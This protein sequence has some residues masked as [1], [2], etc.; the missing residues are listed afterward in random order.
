MLTKRRKIGYASGIVSESVLYNM[1]YT[2][3]LI[4]LTDVVHINPALAGTISMVSIIWDGITDP[5][6]GHMTDKN[7]V[8]KRKVMR[9]SIIPMVVFFVF[10]FT[11]FN[12][13]ASFKV[14]Y[15][16][17]AAVLFWIAY[18]TYTIPYYAICAQITDDYDERTNI[19]GISS[20]INAFA[21]FIGAAAPVVLVE[22]FTGLNLSVETGWMLSAVVVAIIAV[23]FG[24]IAYN[25]TKNLKLIKS[26]EKSEQ[27][28]FKTYLEIIKIKPFKYLLL[29]VVFFMIQ[30]ALGQANL[31]Y[32][33]THRLLV[34]ADAY[35]PI[36]LGAIV[37]GMILFVPLTTKIST[38]K[39]RRYAVILLLSISTLG[40][41]AFFFIGITTVV[42]LVVMLLFYAMGLAVFWTTFYS[43]TY[44]IAELDEMKNNRRRV[45]AI[46][47]LPQFLQ[48]FGAALGMQI[49]GLMLYFFGY[50][51]SKPAQ[52]LAT[53]MGIEYIITV[54]CPI[55]MGL[56]IVFMILYPV[57]KEKYQ[58]LQVAL[59]AKRNGEAYKTDGLEKLL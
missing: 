57:T 46:T 35:M 58:K 44:D 9:A 6:V 53:A 17:L 23:A 29:F 20:F 45:G 28:V 11:S 32:L 36:A 50:D 59:V 37:V 51:A 22:A 55:V 54:I 40:M 5:L 13:N 8:D 39:D 14:I 1:F 25:S 2:Y 12:I 7:N 27:G 34:D 43:F 18:T 16:L 26:Q 10:A 21:I 3:F 52:S 4:F 41:F 47:S 33:I 48:K 42:S 19:R 31:M 56:S 38:L 49:L 24:I 15:Y 30:N